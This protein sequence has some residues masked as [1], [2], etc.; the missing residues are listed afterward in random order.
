M[1]R[2]NTVK[3]RRRH[4]GKK[5]VVPRREVEQGR[6][7][8]WDVLAEGPVD[9]PQA[10]VYGATADVP[11]AEA[12]EG[13]EPAAA[14]DEAA[15]SVQHDNPDWRSLSWFARRAYVER[16]TGTRPAS[17]NHAEDLMHPYEDD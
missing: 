15:T 14:H 5:R 11:E 4:D 17:A 8:G 12:A 3:I 13:P 7:P 6:W 16:V 1:L 10:G 9:A 2:P